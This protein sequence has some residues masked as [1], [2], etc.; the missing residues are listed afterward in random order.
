MAV[1]LFISSENCIA[2]E[3][4]KTC[5]IGVPIMWVSNYRYPN[6]KSSSWIQHVPVIGLHDK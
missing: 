2:K 5:V 6:K 3:A 1:V 4:I